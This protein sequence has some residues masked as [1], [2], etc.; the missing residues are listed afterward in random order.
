[1]LLNQTLQFISGF[2]IN[3]PFSLIMASVSANLACK[4]PSKSAMAT[5]SALINGTGTIGAA[6]GPSLAGIV[7]ESSWKNVFWMCMV[8][9][10]LAV[11]MLSRI[12]YQDA[13]MLLKK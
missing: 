4:V 1:M 2:C 7:S 12:G 13:K 6:I 8:G 10:V 11:L 5:V 3:G 9:D